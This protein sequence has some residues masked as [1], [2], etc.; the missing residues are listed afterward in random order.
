[1]DPRREIGRSLN[2]GE[3]G[4]SLLRLAMDVLSCYLRRKRVGC[5]Q[6]NDGWILAGN[7]IVEVARGVAGMLLILAALESCG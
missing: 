6:R 5:L 3:R 7:S 2:Y 4:P 1:M